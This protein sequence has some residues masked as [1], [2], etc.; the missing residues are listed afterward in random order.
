MPTD[1]DADSGCAAA[2]TSRIRASRLSSD[3]RA[4]SAM[5]KVANS[6]RMMG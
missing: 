4:I 5:P 3:S 2:L 6:F 1:F